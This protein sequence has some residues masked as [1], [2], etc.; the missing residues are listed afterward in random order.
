MFNTIIGNELLY[1]ATTAEV[2]IG[3]SDTSSSGSG[4][5]LLESSEGNTDSTTNEAPADTTN[6]EGET[7]NTEATNVEGD[8]ADTEV[9]NVEG[10]SAN[11]DV[12]N[13]EG[14]TTDT[15]TTDVTVEGDADSTNME[16][17]VDEGEVIDGTG[18]TGDMAIGGDTSIGG[19]MPGV[20]GT[21][22]ETTGS[23]T[24][25]PFLSSYVPIAGISAA[26]LVV[27][28]IIGILL[29]KKKIKKGID[30]YED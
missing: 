24:K 22:G 25:D 29:A 11:T 2:K 30:L 26:T 28:V 27:G 5:N 16:T 1:T 18:D 7:T 15:D 21:Y 4:G 20:D 6:V 14:E 13:V 19:D 17:G 10:D 3:G 23:T 12:T 9:S 8:T